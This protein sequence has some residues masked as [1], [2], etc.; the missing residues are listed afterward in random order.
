MT[1]VLMVGVLLYYNSIIKNI[2]GS[3]F[4]LFCKVNYFMI[5]LL[6]VFYMPKMYIFLYT[7]KLII[8]ILINRNVY[9]FMFLVLIAMQDEKTN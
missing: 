9:F 3:C 1:G 6:I 5:Q 7:K 8:E 2:L 4:I